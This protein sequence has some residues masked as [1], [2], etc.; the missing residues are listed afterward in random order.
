MP[1]TWR[2]FEL[3]ELDEISQFIVELFS[4]EVLLE[5][6]VPE[7]VVGDGVGVGVGT[8]E[9]SLT[10]DA[11]GEGLGDGVGV[12]DEV[13]RSVLVFPSGCLVL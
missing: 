1:V 7:V 3:L 11:E 8:V 10:G 2:Q 9:V 5:D 6:D 12:G 13:T 4:A